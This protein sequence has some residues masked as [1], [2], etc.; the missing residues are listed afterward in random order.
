MERGQQPLTAEK[1][2][3][4]VQQILEQQREQVQNLMDIQMESW[5]LRWLAEQ[6]SDTTSRN[7]ASSR[8]GPEETQLADELQN[9]LNLST[10]QMEQ[11]KQV[12]FSVKMILVTNTFTPFGTPISLLLV[13]LCFL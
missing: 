6:H 1:R 8:M 11:L 12:R 5:M 2:R 3:E 9:V 13:L 7:A 10:E 4:V